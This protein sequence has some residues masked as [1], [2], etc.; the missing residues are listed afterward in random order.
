MVT[1]YIVHHGP[2]AALGRFLPAGPDTAFRRGDRVVVRTGRGPELG[3]VL[4]EAT[5]RHAAWL[6]AAAAGAGDLLGHAT[7]ADLRRAADAEAV[8]A[9]VLDAAAVLAAKHGLPLTP[10][11]ADATLDGG[12]VVLHVVR[13]GPCDA[14]PLCEELARQYGLRVALLDLTDDRP[15]PA[16]GGCSTCGTEGG[17]STCGTGS[18]CGTGSC[19]K[20]AAKTAD[21]MTAYFAGLR[22]QMEAAAVARTPLL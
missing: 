15:K 1:T 9:C 19:A 10:L 11:D 13:S 17:C 20:G 14:D 4:C 3:E 2:N 12:H 22:R 8:A 5:E 16:A 7:D 18:G 21:E 6:P